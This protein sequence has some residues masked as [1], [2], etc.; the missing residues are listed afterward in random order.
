[1]R[2]DRS[3]QLQQEANQL[4]LKQLIALEEIRDIYQ[5]RLLIKQQKL[6]IKMQINNIVFQ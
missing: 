6:Q 4:A 3:I 5:Q 1:M 2:L